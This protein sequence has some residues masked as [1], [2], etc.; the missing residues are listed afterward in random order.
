MMSVH[1]CFMA[2]C[3]I[4]NFYFESLTQM[5]RDFA[6]L[7][8]SSLDSPG[9]LVILLSLSPQCWDYSRVHQTHFYSAFSFCNWSN[10]RNS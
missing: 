4:F 7:T 8:W 6:R 1:P 3:R 5:H 10:S 9:Y 2:L